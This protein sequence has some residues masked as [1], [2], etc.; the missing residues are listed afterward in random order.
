M[1]LIGHSTSGSRKTMVMGAWYVAL[2]AVLLWYTRHERL[3]MVVDACFATIRELLA[4]NV[5]ADVLFLGSSRTLRGVVPDVF[6]QRCQAAIGTSVTALNLAILGE[7]R[8]VNYHVLRDYLSDHAAPNVVFVE[9]GMV[10]VSEDAHALVSRFM[11]VEDALRMVWER[12]YVYCRPWAAEAPAVE[13]GGNPWPEAPAVDRDIGAIDRF[14]L[15]CSIALDALGRGPE[16]LVRALY[17]RIANGVGSWFWAAEGESGGFRGF[18]AGLHNPYRSPEAR[19]DMSFV[20]RGVGARGW[21]GWQALDWEQAV[22]AKERLQERASRANVD[23]ILRQRN[24][25]IDLDDPERFRAARI[26]TRLLA[27]LCR[28]R[29]IRLIMMEVPG[30]LE[31]TLSASQ[32]RFYREEAELFRPNRTK[33]YHESLYQDMGHFNH[34][35]AVLFT[36]QLVRYLVARPGH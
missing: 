24:R 19:I 28:E 9:V 26:Y 35:G 2:C 34:D 29:G 8:Q 33:L 18:L 36:E 17:N 32:E 27:D 6:E 23:G 11:D 12:P 1:R 21:L 7:P 4:E 31:P 15:H 25:D 10:D 13:V 30:F 5:H 14:G 16:D 20:E 22:A 3:Q